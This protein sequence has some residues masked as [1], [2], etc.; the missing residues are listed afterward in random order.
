MPLYELLDDQDTVIERRFLP[1]ETTVGTGAP[2]EYARMRLA[3]V[4]P[5]PDRYLV[6]KLV[7]VDRLIAA[8][9]LAAA[10]A[11]LAGASLAT[12]QRWA[13]AGQIYSDD[14]DALA[15]LAAIGAD[16]DAILAVG[17]GQ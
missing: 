14:P 12:Q 6:P 9:K 4:Q 8:G 1:A 7:V 5:G 15:L 17:D 10:V 3:A 16:P 11:A 13:A 2:G